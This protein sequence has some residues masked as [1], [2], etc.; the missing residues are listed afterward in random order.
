MKAINKFFILL[1]II[2]T[3]SSCKKDE[4]NNTN[5]L[6]A[7]ELLI[8]ANNSIQDDDYYIEFDWGNVANAEEYSFQISNDVNF[9]NIIDS[10]VNSNSSANVNSSLLTSNAVYYWRV[11]AIA[12]GYES[13]NYSEV[14][15][16]TYNINGGGSFNL[17][18]PANN[19]QNVSPNATFVCESVTGASLYTFVFTE[20]SGGGGSQSFTETS[21]TPNVVSSQLLPNTIYTWYVYAEVSGNYEYSPEW[22]FQTESGTPSP[23]NGTYNGYGSGP[24]FISSVLDTTFTNLP[25]EITV[26]ETSNGSGVFNVTYDFDVNG[27]N[28]NPTVQGI[29]SGSS[30]V[31]TNQSYNLMGIVDLLI[32]DNISFNGSNTA[33][34]GNATLGS[35]SGSSIVVNGN[36]SYSASK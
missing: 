7:P 17:V 15:S 8:P 25:I 2:T 28:V 21:V 14:F 34:T 11:K 20:A 27:I 31:I 19:S 9:S 23:K 18:S 30:I 1:L 13:S 10:E 24:I 3:I 5:K 16:F 12:G 36:L 22:S 33:I 4:D 32:N 26:Q 35:V 6:D 29:E